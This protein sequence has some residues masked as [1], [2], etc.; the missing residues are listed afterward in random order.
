MDQ[1][2]VC[3]IV[4]TI[5]R[6]SVCFGS[7]SV[8]LLCG[9]S[10]RTLQS[11][12]FLELPSVFC[13]EW[14]MEGESARLP[15]PVCLSLYVFLRVRQYLALAFNTAELTLCLQLSIS[16]SLTLLL[17]PLLFYHS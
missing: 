11:V 4:Y 3:T 17:F 16:L 10:R 9:C 2:C 12:C 7:V 1:V 5:I 6:I 13:V 8:M 14:E 15:V